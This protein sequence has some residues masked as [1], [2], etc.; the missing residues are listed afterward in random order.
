MTET[1]TTKDENEPGHVGAISDGDLSPSETA[2]TS[3]FSRQNV[4]FVDEKS[5]VHE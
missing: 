5:V 1:F 2:P 4:A 3:A